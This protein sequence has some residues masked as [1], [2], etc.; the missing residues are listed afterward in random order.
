MRWRVICHL[1]VEFASTIPLLTL[2]HNVS[3]L[4]DNSSLYPSPSSCFHLCLSG[5][6]RLSSGGGAFDVRCLVWGGG[7]HINYLYVLPNRK[8]EGESCPQLLV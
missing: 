6:V 2:M 1:C 4:C 8:V 3:T 7:E 5:T